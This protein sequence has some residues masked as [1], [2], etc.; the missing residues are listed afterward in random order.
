MIVQHQI[1]RLGHLGDGIAEG[2]VFAPRTLPGETVSGVLNDGQLTEVKI[3]TP[4][5]DRVRP[6]CRHYTS[7]GGCQLQHASDPFVADFKQQV[8]SSALSAQ[9]LVARA[10]PILTSP[11]QS[12]RRATISVRR[13]K[14]GAL[15]GF[16]GRASDV[17]IQVPD[18]LLLDARM[19]PGL[20]VAEALA[21]IGASRKGELSVTLTLSAAGLDVAVEGGKPVD[22]PLRVSLA[23]AVEQYRLARLSWNDEFVATRDPPYQH[24]GG[25]K[26]VPPPGAFLQATQRGESDL[27]SAVHGIAKGADRVVDLFAGCG[28]FSL[29]LARTS[30]VLAV[31]GSADMIAALDRAWREAADLKRVSSVVR[32]LFR[33]P[34]LS[35]EL[36]AFDAAVLDP[37]RAGAEAQVAE[38]ARA[39]IP[40]VAYVSCNPVTFA[41]DAR[42][43]VDAGY[44]IDWVQV[45]DQFRW[46]AHVELVAAFV[47]GKTEKEPQRTEM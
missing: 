35:D 45:V 13:T 12:R 16:H 21:C 10:R 42:T 5:A 8:V 40:R 29:P 23:Q 7:C 24:F 18:C 14:K 28:T 46:S 26:V 47:Y 38:L 34:L 11:P 20:D 44:K 15:A 41:R 43:L 31:E 33:R 36:S 3:V 1:V 32:D 2:P 19:L 22:G 39:G 9:G 6:P 25:T 30:E 4:S 17:I 37:P 27:L